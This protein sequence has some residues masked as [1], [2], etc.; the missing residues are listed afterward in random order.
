MSNYLS[1]HEDNKKIILRVTI[2]VII[3]NIFLVA[4]KTVFGLIYGNLAVLSD[5]VHSASDLVTSFFVILAVFMSSPKR[6]KKHNYGH[7]KVESLMVMFFAFV[8]AGIGGFFIWQGIEGILSPQSGVFNLS[9]IIVIAVSMLVKE[10]LFWYGM[11]Y[12]KKTKSELL[13]ADAW[14]SRSDSLASLAVLVGL[15]CSI[16]MDSNLVESIAVLVVALFIIKVAF[17]IFKPA[18][19]Q[20]VDRAASSKDVERINQIASAV[21]GVRKIDELRTRIFGSA[22]LVDISIHVDALLTVQ[23]GHDIAEKVH[24]ELESDSDLRIKHCNVHVNPC[25]CEKHEK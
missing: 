11:H 5:A 6:D 25:A 2:I 24:D 23:Q 1:N 4:I 8:L 16:F 7:E 21:E 19:D 10:A 9:L 12:A 18:V 13:R 20:L 14:H 15:V 17:D 3:A 22:I